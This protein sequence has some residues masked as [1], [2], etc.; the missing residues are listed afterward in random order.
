MWDLLWTKWYGGRYSSST[1]VCLATDC[2]I[3]IIKGWCN[4]QCIAYLP[5]AFG[6]T[7]GLES[8]HHCKNLVFWDV[9]PCGSC[10]NR[11]FSKA[12]RLLLQGE[13]NQRN[14]NNVSINMNCSTLRRLIHNFTY[15]NVEGRLLK[16]SKYTTASRHDL[17][18]LCSPVV[19]VPGYR[20]RSSVFDAWRYQIF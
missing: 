3:L 10:K 19:I 20:S 18:R 17:D 1:S 16:Q 6:L 11:R 2:S 15:F 14:R 13:N 4:S 8:S 7:P 5:R 12:Y 9:T